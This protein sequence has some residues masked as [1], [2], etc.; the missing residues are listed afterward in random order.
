MQ[1]KLL[2]ER[3]DSS[4]YLPHWVP[5]GGYLVGQVLQVDGVARG[6]HRHP[7]KLGAEV[8]ARASIESD[9]N[10]IFETQHC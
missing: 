10:Q 6:A 4:R 9:V 8:V 7:K 2:K 1:A 5:R 3:G